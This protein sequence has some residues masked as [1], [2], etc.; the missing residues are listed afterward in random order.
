MNRIKRYRDN[1]SEWAW[2]WRCKVIPKKDAEKQPRPIDDIDSLSDDDPKRAAASKDPTLGVQLRVKTFYEGRRSDPSSHSFDWQD[3]PPKQVSAAAAKN[4]SAFAIK[5]YKVKDREK[6][7]IAGRFPLRFHMIEVQNPALVEAIEPVLKREDVHLDVNETATFHAPFR[8]LYFGWAGIV[9]L[10]KNT[11]DDSPLKGYLE[12]FV[13][14]LDDM[15]G[16]LRVKMRHLRASKLINFKNAWAYFPKDTTVYSFGKNSELLCRV[17]ST[18]YVKDGLAI[19]A[20]MLAFNGEEFVWKDTT[21]VIPPFLGNK[22]ITDLMYYPL[23]FHADPEGL[24]RR[25]RERGRRV[26]DLQGLCYRTYNGIALV[27]GAN[28]DIQKHNVDSR[29]LIDVVGFNKYHLAQGKRESKDP[30]TVRNAATRRPKSS[31]V[32]DRDAQNRNLAKP[33]SRRLSEDDQQKNKD[34]MLE[35]EDELM[36]MSPLIEGYALKNKMWG[37]CDADSPRGSSC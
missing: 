26:L 32:A 9:E 14:L 34:E 11:D 29:I 31:S 33:T 20:R 10:Y 8:P 7:P 16:E 15:F 22:P 27:E 30:E 18:A 19:A 5:V 2:K 21:L 17:K 1:A 25:L 12:L 23:D 37:K 4:I 6:T 35:K 36:F 3:Y 24:K 28:D 13:R